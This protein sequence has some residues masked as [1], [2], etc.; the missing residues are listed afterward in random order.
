MSGIVALHSGAL[1]ASACFPAGRYG[2]TP[3]PAFRQ[4]D[5]AY[6]SY[7]VVYFKKEQEKQSNLIYHYLIVLSSLTGF[8]VHFPAMFF[9][10]V[11]CHPSRR[12]FC[13]LSH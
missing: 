11:F 2:V 3:L 6:L 10:Y 9:R 8:S 13:L 1:R 7:I 5:K 12:R 4:D